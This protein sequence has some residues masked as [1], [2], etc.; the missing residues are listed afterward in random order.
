MKKIFVSLRF[1][2]PL[3]EN[4]VYT[5]IVNAKIENN[6]AIVSPSKI[7]KNVF[8]FELPNNSIIHY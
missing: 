8:G 7:F 3:G 1:K 5:G 6:K 4:L 2:L